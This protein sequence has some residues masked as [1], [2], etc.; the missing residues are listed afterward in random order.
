MNTMPTW[1]LTASGMFFVLGSIAMLVSVV[2]LAILGYAALE[3]RKGVQ[4]LSVK[5]DTITTKVDDIATNL[6]HVTTEVSTRTTGMV[7]MIDD[8]AGGA[9]T[10]VEK[11]APVLVG[12]AAAARIFSAFRG[13]RR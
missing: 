3:L 11:F 13:R 1:W 7:R 2:L 12:I 8:A 5:I 6:K 10:I 4:E 9:M